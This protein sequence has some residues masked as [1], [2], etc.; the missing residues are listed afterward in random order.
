MMIHL[1]SRE[2]KVGSVYKNV[3]LRFFPHMQ[4]PSAY[5]MECLSSQGF[6]CLRLLVHYYLLLL[7]LCNG[8]TY[9]KK[10]GGKMLLI[11]ESI[12]MGHPQ[13]MFSGKT[14]LRGHR[15]LRSHKA[16]DYNSPEMPSRTRNNP[17]F[18]V[19]GESLHRCW[20]FTIISSSS[21]LA[22]LKAENLQLQEWCLDLLN[23]LKK[24]KERFGCHNYLFLLIYTLLICYCMIYLYYSW[25]DGLFGDVFVFP[26]TKSLAQPRCLFSPQFLL[27]C[28]SSSFCLAVP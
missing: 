15:G 21:L 25:A 11:E 6:V 28:L 17:K 2:E 24:E 7:Q 13:R 4:L 10:D 23:N 14:G 22:Q 5:D 1:L 3:I 27:I 26:N 20:K 18:K 8:A 12:I 9:A 19:T 16:A